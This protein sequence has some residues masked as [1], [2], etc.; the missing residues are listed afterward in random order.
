VAQHETEF[1]NEASNYS[2]QLKRIQARKLSA[3][4]APDELIN[5]R[6]AIFES[7]HYLI[8]AEALLDA[9]IAVRNLEFVRDFFHRFPLFALASPNLRQQQFQTLFRLGEWAA[10]RAAF[11]PLQSDEVLNQKLAHSLDICSFDWE[12]LG[13][14]L[15][16][17]VCND[18]DDSSELLYL[19]KQ[20]LF[21]RDESLTMRFVKR[22]VD[23]NPAN[24]DVCMQAYLFK[25]QLGQEQEPE[26]GLWIKTAMANQNEH[27]S[28]RT[29]RPEDLVE[30]S[31]GWRAQNTSINRGIAKAELPL[32]VVSEN[33]NSSL[34]KMLIETIEENLVQQSPHKRR[35]VPA[36]AGQTRILVSA[37]STLYMDASTLL[38]LAQLDILD[39]LF[40]CFDEVRV[41][42]SL[43]PWL[44]DEVNKLTFHQPSRIQD[45]L[46]LQG[47]FANG[48]LNIAD[49]VKYPPSGLVN[50][51]GHDLAQLLLTARQLNAG[52]VQAFVVHPG[53]VYTPESLRS[54]VANI[55][56]DTRFLLNTRVLFEA[57]AS[58]G[59][60]S[61]EKLQA[62]QDC[63]RHHDELWESASSILPAQ[64]TLLL[65]DLA[66]EFLQSGDLLDPLTQCGFHLFA[67]PNKRYECGELVRLQ[68]IKLRERQTLDRLRCWLKDQSEARFVKAVTKAPHDPKLELHF[69]A[70]SMVQEFLTQ[71]ATTR[72][73]VFDDRALNKSEIVN[74]ADGSGSTIRTSL[75]VLNWLREKNRIS[76]ADL[77][78]KRMHLRRASLL[79]IP[80]EE[81]ELFAAIQACSVANDELVE[82][83]DART[84]REY[85]QLAQSSGL[86]QVNID[87]P[88]LFNVARVAMHVIEKLWDSELVDR[89]TEIQSDWLIDLSEALVFND[90]AVQFEEHALETLQ[91]STLMRLVGISLTQTKNKQAFTEWVDVYYFQRFQEQFPNQFNAAV[92]WTKRQFFSLKK[93]A[94]PMISTMFMESLPPTLKAALDEELFR[95]V[96]SDTNY[97]VTINIE[98]NPSFDT[99]QLYQTAQMTLQ[100]VEQQSI[101]DETGVAW[102]FYRQ[103]SGVVEAREL[104]GSRT[105]RLDSVALVAPE[106]QAR[107]RALEAEI[108]N[109]GI[110]ESDAEK[111][112]TQIKIGPFDHHQF[113]QLFQLGQQTPLSVVKDLGAKFSSG[114]S[115]SSLVEGSD[116][117]FERLVGKWH[118]G[119][120]I[121]DSLHDSRRDQSQTH[122]SRHVATIHALTLSSLAQRLLL[123]RLQHA[124][125][126][127][128]AH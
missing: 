93:E 72:L 15:R 91:G 34:S 63:L 123:S 117:Y 74:H 110:S 43:G 52:G 17:I 40:G 14:R 85:L 78:S 97:T 67:H 118:W 128:S 113:F 106:I 109:L 4:T 119:T 77:R 6:T 21:L 31:E 94:A 45:A 92:A 5:L 47:A 8:D 126:N 11:Q 7:T 127:H 37:P 3:N 48:V 39:S 88:W 28:V 80:I 69:F 124:P 49:V 71:P 79:F 125:R 51:V 65:D 44:L 35:P 30:Q 29:I 108:A 82:S 105:F 116:A 84:V 58:R 25:S 42:H 23:L 33:S 16:A 1:E 26:A 104:S 70:T 24:A 55:G 41:A 87:M 61:N 114:F 75:D 68:T 100:H 38:V 32:S 36:F 122:Q 81:D 112:R 18:L 111:F 73:A 50:Q 60:L 2:L 12:A 89:K 90:E 121:L 46:A 102:V 54:E 10:A 53:K 57:L 64:C 107:E 120:R 115:W 101:V 98:G 20:S 59:A 103:D 62:A 96:D 9:H 13:V 66:V 56:D 86:T 83:N 99:N 22:A 95:N 76:E 19:A 27:S